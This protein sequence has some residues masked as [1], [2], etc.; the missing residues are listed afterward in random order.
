MRA[1][2]VSAFAVVLVGGCGNGPDHDVG[3][4]L[5][6]ITG[7]GSG[8]DGGATDSDGPGTEVGG[9]KFDLPPEDTDGPGGG[10]DCP[11]D[12]GSGNEDYDFS[13]I[14]VANSPEGTVSKIDTKTATELA[15]YRTGPDAPDPSRT[16]VNLKGDVAIGNRSGSVT[17]IAARE[18]ACLDANN[19]GVITTSQ[20]PDDI[21]DWGGDE[22]VLWHH[23]IDFPTGLNANQGGPRGIAWDAN[24]NGNPCD[25]RPNLWVGWRNQ[26]E[27]TVTVRQLDGSTGDEIGQV[28]VPDWEGKW[29]HG[30]YGGA[31]D[32]S[33]AFWGLGTLGTLIR[34]TPET[35]EVTRW[36]NE[37]DTN[38]YGLALDA[39]GNPWMGGFDGN[40]WR[41][42]V[43]TETFVDL[44]TTATSS[45]L[46]GLAI[47]SN[48]YAWIAANNPCGL[49]QY[50]TTSDTVIQDA[51]A[52]ENCSMP[53]GVSIDSEGY[54]WVVDR[55]ADQAYKVH[56]ET[57]ETVIVDG[58]VSPYTYSDMTGAGLDLVIN[59]PG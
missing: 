16:S 49:V 25:P 26:P 52:L 39:A 13:I 54:V 31:S 57:Y 27:T 41:F 9:E 21:L 28:V 34:V 59:P 5:D 1:G 8:S 51:I 22:C 23:N 24:D 37:V 12:P 50:D 32:K 17:K 42:D 45:R 55:D 40:L 4:G 7:G 14:W 35:F 3:G 20:G 6:G 19:D 2:L 47:D 48:G 53:V 18:T 46:R 38:P 10:G 30:T 15:R 56:P 44:G 58:L 36:D 29:G 33:G 43:A 11:S